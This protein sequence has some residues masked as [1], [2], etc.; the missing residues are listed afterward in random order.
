MCINALCISC[1]SSGLPEAWYVEVR[2]SH[3]A[4]QLAA[5]S[6]LQRAHLQKWLRP[7]N[8]ATELL[9][10]AQHIKSYQATN[11]WKM[12]SEYSNAMTDDMQEMHHFTCWVIIALNFTMIC[13][14]TSVGIWH[15]HPGNKETEKPVG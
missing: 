11:L 1:S 6:L 3:P 9:P 5:Q 12:Q 2:S 7:W 10:A 14:D 15:V 4:G 8:L 13:C